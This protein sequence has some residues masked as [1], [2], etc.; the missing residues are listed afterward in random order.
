MS[1]DGSIL[2]ID[3]GRLL[4]DGVDVLDL[5]QRIQTPFFVYSARAVRWNVES[6]RNAFTRRHI[7]TDI[8]YAS[9]ACSLMWFLRQVL[10][11]GT[12][13][14]VNSGGELWK[15][16]KAGFRPDQIVFNGIAKTVPEIREALRVG[17]RTI[18]I[19]S[20][21]ELERVAGT[22]SELG[23]PAPVALRV[24]VD[25]PTQTH[26]GM[27][28]THGSKFGADIDQA[29]D[30]YR[31][32]AAHEWLRPLGLHAHLGSQITT[33]DPYVRGIDAALDLVAEI[34]ASC[35]VTLEVLDI[36][37][38]FPVPFK[39]ADGP[40]DPADYFRAPIGLDDYAEAIC[41]ALRAR[42]PD[43][44]L[45]VEPGRAIAAP[46]AILVTRVQNEK[47]K[48]VRDVQGGHVGDERW[49]IL[50][51]GYNTLLEHCLYD[52][53]YPCVVAGRLVETPGQP[54]RIGGPLCDAGDAFVGDDDDGCRRLPAGTSVGDVVVFSQVGA[55]GLDMMTPCNSRPRAAVYAVEDGIVRRVRR[56][57]TYSDMIAHDEGWEP[58]RPA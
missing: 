5:A 55:Y 21:F 48:Y 43:L 8:L 50:D 32:A 57:E 26:P 27:A 10:G 47:L 37:G 16:L 29:V 45:F 4:I 24:D 34:E 25:V 46:A 2:D 15:A 20:L 42:R 30:G 41:G 9:K 7:D 56:E 35:D 6:L 49:I 12:D 17:I 54:F 18:I 51:A 19:D 22:A 3:E 23:T 33:T 13:I 31:F 58:R 36:G 40:V 39:P 52:W 1:P 44:R 11:S 53:Y 38:G 14:E 28:T